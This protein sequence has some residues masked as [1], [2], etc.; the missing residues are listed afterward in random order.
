MGRVSVPALWCTRSRANDV[1]TRSGPWRAR[2]TTAWVLASDSAL[3]PWKLANRPRMER[4]SVRTYS[5]R[6]RK[7]TASHAIASATTTHAICAMLRP[8]TSTRSASMPAA[9][10]L[11][12]PFS[13]PTSM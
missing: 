12:R 9:S 6:I 5:R 4:A 11:P 8:S 13:T 2:R 3:S 1:W 10:A 7:V